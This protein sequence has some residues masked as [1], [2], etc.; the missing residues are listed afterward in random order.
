MIL[1]LGQVRLQAVTFGDFCVNV[2]VDVPLKVTGAAKQIQT[3][4]LGLFLFEVPARQK[5]SAVRQCYTWF[6]NLV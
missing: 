4:L 3:T 1:G 6:V 5:Y 2:I